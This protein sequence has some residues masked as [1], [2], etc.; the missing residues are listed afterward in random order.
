MSL[1]EALNKNTA[2][3]N[4]LL[5]VLTNGQVEGM[6]A[7]LGK[8]KA[9]TAK[10]DAPKADTKKA[11]TVKADA[12]KADAPKADTKKADTA[13]DEIPEEYLPVRTITLQLHKKNRALASQLLAEFGCEK[14]ARELDASQYDAYVARANELLTDSEEE[15][16]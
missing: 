14:S 4:G 10:T 13:K 12:K 8:G 6:P 16:A 7:F 5:S 11:E 3:V 15:I 9:D 1:E 2:A